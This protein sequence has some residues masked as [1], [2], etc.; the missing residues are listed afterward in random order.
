VSFTKAGGGFFRHMSPNLKEYV[1]VGFNADGTVHLHRWFY[2][3]REAGD[4]NIP[5]PSPKTN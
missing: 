3:V 4:P 5:E 1:W 2:R